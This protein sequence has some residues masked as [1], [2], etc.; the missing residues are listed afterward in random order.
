MSIKLNNLFVC[1]WNNWFHPPDP[2]VPFNINAMMKMPH[3]SSYSSGLSV[4][5]L[6]LDPCYCLLCYHTGT[7]STVKVWTIPSHFYE[8]GLTLTWLA[9]FEYM[10]IL[11]PP[12]L[13][14]SMLWF[15]RQYCSIMLQFPHSHI[16]C[17]P[18]VGQPSYIFLIYQVMSYSKFRSCV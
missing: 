18:A 5:L 4:G 7:I 13:N 10:I 8:S 17:K 11:F 9:C 3:S 2:V 12:L 16:T 1:P 15:S 6:R 14:V